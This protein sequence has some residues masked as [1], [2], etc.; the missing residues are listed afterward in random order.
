MSLILSYDFIQVLTG[1]VTSLP[2]EPLSDDSSGHVDGRAANNP[3]RR[4]GTPCVLLTVCRV[5]VPRTRHDNFPC[6]MQRVVMVSRDCPSKPRR[7][8][9]QVPQRSCNN[10]KLLGDLRKSNL[11]TRHALEVSYLPPLQT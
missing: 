9:I 4:R 5:M 6:P 2:T 11:P 7:G 8:D 1:C 3:L 10:A